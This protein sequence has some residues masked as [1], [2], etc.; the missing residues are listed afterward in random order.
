MLAIDLPLGLAERGE[1]VLT[2]LL[3]PLCLRN[4]TASESEQQGQAGVSV[5]VGQSWYWEIELQRA[6]PHV[7]TARSM[8]VCSSRT[9]PGQS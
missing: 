6:D 1:D 8:T 4:H 5:M 7:M 2:P 9:L 3:F